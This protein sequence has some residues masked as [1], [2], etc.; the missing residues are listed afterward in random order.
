ML[1]KILATA[2]LAAILSA[3]GAMA[4]TIKVGVTPGEHAQILEKVKEVAK[5]KGLDIEIFEFSDYVVPN[6]AL[7]DGELDANSFQHKPYLDNQIA[8]R[9][10]DLGRCRLY[11]QFP[12]GRLFEKSEEFR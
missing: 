7:N 6:Q 8:D 11:G 3:T 1:K 9:K 5:P 12:D 4:E 10:F 2:A